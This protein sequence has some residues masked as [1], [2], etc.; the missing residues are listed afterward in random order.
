[1]ARKP[2][3]VLTKFPNNSFKLEST[4][5]SKSKCETKKNSIISIKYYVLII[6]LIGSKCIND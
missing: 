1:M 2:V 4:F 5:G 6:N 3:V